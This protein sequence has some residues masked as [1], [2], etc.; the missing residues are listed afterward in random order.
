MDDL[1]PHTLTHHRDGSTRLTNSSP[2]LGLDL[3]SHQAVPSFCNLPTLHSFGC[4]IQIM[5]SGPEVLWKT[6]RD[7]S[8][9]PNGA[10]NENA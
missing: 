7:I 6:L 4:N 1:S 3:A 10:I 8:A 5:S 2:H 9:M